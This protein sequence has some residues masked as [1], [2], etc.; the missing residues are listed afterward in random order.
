MHSH[1]TTRRRT[2]AKGRPGVYFRE[3]GGRRRYEITYLDETGA[4]RWKTIRDDAQPLTSTNEYLLADRPVRD[5]RDEPRR[6]VR[7]A[8]TQ[9]QQKL[10]CA[11]ATALELSRRDGRSSHGHDGTHEFSTS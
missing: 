7:L 10:E 9:L 3:V 6:V 5:S 11:D 1:S 8:V 2:K 4:R